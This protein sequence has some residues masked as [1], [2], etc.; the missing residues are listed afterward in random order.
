VIQAA[1]PLDW[2]GR[3]FKAVIP[4]AFIVV[5]VLIVAVAWIVLWRLYQRCPHCR[6]LVPRATGGTRRCRRCGRQ[7]YRGLRNV[8]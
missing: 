2:L 7:Y 8:G 1:G 3:R 5:A 4:Q 6:R